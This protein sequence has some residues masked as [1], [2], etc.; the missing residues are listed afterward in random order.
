MGATAMAAAGKLGASAEIWT[1]IGDDLSGEFLIRDFHR[2]NVDTS[3]V[4]IVPGA[5]TGVCA[6]LVNADT[7]DRRFIFYP[8]RGLDVPLNFDLA[9]IDHAKCILVDGSFIDDAIRAAARARQVGVPVVADLGGLAGKALELAR[10]VDI[11]IVPEECARRYADGADPAVSIPR[12]RDLGPRVVVVTMG[13]RGGLYAGRLR[14]GDP[15]TPLTHYEAFKVPVVDTTGCGDVFHGA[16]CFGL[17]RGWGLDR[18]VQFASATAAL[19]CRELGGRSGIPT[20]DEVQQFLTQ[21]VV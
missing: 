10:L 11:M 9:R 21:Q 5:A 7:G 4:R 2:F 14:D 16:F 19:K 13:D 8:G 3:Q 6:V 17:V 12:I 15:E 18:I 1:R 20:C